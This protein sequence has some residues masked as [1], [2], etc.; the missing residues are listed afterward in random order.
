MVQKGGDFKCGN[1]EGGKLVSG[2]G[3]TRT[4]EKE[5]RSE[6]I[7]TFTGEKRS[8]YGELKLGG[9]VYTGGWVNGVKHGLATDKWPNGD[10]FTGCFTNGKYDDFGKF[11]WTS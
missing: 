2:F 9:H 3:R 11:T 5:V 4:L 10:T 8:G 1:W 6:Y 7:G